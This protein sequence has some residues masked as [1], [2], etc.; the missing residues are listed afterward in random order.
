MRLKQH[1]VDMTVVVDNLKFRERKMQP[2][3][4]EVLINDVD[5]MVLKGRVETCTFK[6]L[7][8]NSDC[9]DEIGERAEG[10]E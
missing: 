3:I 5:G 9:V 4:A 2:P 10:W 8:Q 6:D 7:A 1:L